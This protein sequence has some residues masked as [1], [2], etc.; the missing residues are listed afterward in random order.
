MKRRKNV[1]MVTRRQCVGGA[2]DGKDGL[3]VS[4]KYKGEDPTT[5]PERIENC[6]KGCID[7]D[8]DQKCTMYS[9]CFR[10]KS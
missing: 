3:S 2:L 10:R 8:T 7:E 5:G 9:F 6:H 4:C 1:C